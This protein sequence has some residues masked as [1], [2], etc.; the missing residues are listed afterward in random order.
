MTYFVCIMQLLASSQDLLIFFLVFGGACFIQGIIG[1]GFVILGMPLLFILG[2][3]YKSLIGLF[4]C[5]SLIVNVVML[6]H[7]RGYIK[8]AA[9][10]WY[11]ILGG[12]I[13]S[14]PSTLVLKYIDI[15]YFKFY[16]ALLILVMATLLLLD[17]KIKT[18]N[19][20]LYLLIVGGVT[21]F[22]QCSVALSGPILAYFLSQ[23]KLDIALFKTKMLLFYVA[24]NSV[25]ILLHSQH[26]LINPILINQVLKLVPAVI[27][28][29]FLGWSCSKYFSETIFKKVIVG[30][31]FVK[32]IIIATFG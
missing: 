3:Q 24:M 6:F 19:N 2:Y 20:A 21:G 1:F 16:V 4:I 28:G 15:N 7:Y 13:V 11:L 32:A 23:K 26:H 30:V 14:Y 27:I 12:L 17:V 29:L 31:L 8:K 25:T 10:A 9:S 22:V 18:K 5:M